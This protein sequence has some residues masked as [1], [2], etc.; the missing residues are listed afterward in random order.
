MP[1]KTVALAAAALCAVALLNLPYGYY[2]FL[3]LVVC[4]AS[5]YGAILAMGNERGGWAVTLGLVALLFNPLIPVHLD[6]E[7]WAAVDLLAAVILSVAAFKL[8]KPD[9]EHRAV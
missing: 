7:T 2:T 6:R 1:F 9:P 3:R 5:G 4:G 8:R